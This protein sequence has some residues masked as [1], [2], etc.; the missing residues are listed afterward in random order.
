MSLR[1]CYT[2]APRLEW[3]PDS[4]KAAGGSFGKDL[5]VIANE[6]VRLLLMINPNITVQSDEKFVGQ[7]EGHTGCLGRLQQNLSDVI[8]SESLYPIVGKNLTTGP[9]LLADKTAFVSTY[10][11][12]FPL[13]AVDVMQSFG[14]FSATV[15]IMI[16]LSALFMM[17]MMSSSQVLAKSQRTA[18]KRWAKQRRR[19]EQRIIEK[20][21]VST[22][23][24]A[25]GTIS[26]KKKRQRKHLV[27]T[28]VLLY[29]YL[30]QRSIEQSSRSSISV[31]TLTLMLILLNFY[32]I[33]YFNAIVKTDKVVLLKP[34]TIES[35]D[36][37][38]NS[39][40][41]KRVLFFEDIKSHL[42]FVKAR[43]GSEERRIWQNAMR[44][45]LK[46]SFSHDFAQDG[47]SFSRSEV[48]YVAPV[49]YITGIA[50]GYCLLR[51][52]LELKTIPMGKT[53]ESANDNIYVLMLSG[54]LHSAIAAR[55]RQVF[56]RLLTSAFV[57]SSLAQVQREQGITVE[58]YDICLSNFVRFPDPELS[59]ISMSQCKKLIMTIIFLSVTSCYILLIEILYRKIHSRKQ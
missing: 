37:I 44:A 36:D 25:P 34:A 50:S 56:G 16:M 53:D 3:I 20:E 18:I 14:A 38:L 2:A 1:L 49:T 31:A 46:N 11:N 23:V 4:R 52:L 57:P 12:E 47:V 8:S 10:L 41:N 55:V 6:C 24:S 28:R 27:R 26:E 45:G 9:V 48:I 13:L 7:E 30:I 22:G 42:P 35:Y 15:W 58:D 40:P 32:A 17:F 5:S 39:Y 59:A 29:N 33:F 51:R 21:E 43:A 19:L 54:H